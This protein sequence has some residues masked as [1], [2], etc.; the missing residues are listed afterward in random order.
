MCAFFSFSFCLPPPWPVSCPPRCLR[1]FPALLR[2]DPFLSSKVFSM[3]P[4]SIPIICNRLCTSTC[5]ARE[6]RCSGAASYTGAARSQQRGGAQRI[7]ASLDTTS[8]QPSP[9]TVS[10][11]RNKIPPSPVLLSPQLLPSYLSIDPRTVTPPR[12]ANPP[13]PPSRASTPR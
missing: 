11:P 3:Y 9:S 1:V 12:T 7:S 2:P 4:I 6:A 10:L 13:W 8:N 5:A